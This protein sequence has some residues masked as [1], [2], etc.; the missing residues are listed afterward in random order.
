VAPPLAAV[1]A[2]PAKAKAPPP[3]ATTS[4]PAAQFNLQSAGYGGVQAFLK[5]WPNKIDVNSSPNGD[6]VIFAK[7]SAVNAKAEPPNAQVV[8]AAKSMAP[9]AVKSPAPIV[10]AKPAAPVPPPQA[11]APPVASSDALGSSQSQTSP[12]S[13]A[14]ELDDPIP[15]TGL[16]IRKELARVAHEMGRI[17]DRQ[18][19]LMASAAHDMGR[20]ADRQRVLIAALNLIA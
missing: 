16:E 19:V 17:A 15:S 4:E 9:A 18:R 11:I 2:I 10:P 6:V 12:V 3:T 7:K 13:G 14:I 1:P 5:A 20:M 8:T